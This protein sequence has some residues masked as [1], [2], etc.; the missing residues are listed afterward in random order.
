MPPGPVRLTRR[1]S[2][3]ARR[4]RRA[5]SSASRPI[6]G[7]GGAGRAPPRGPA[8]PR[9]G[10]A[11]GAPRDPPEGGPAVADAADAAGGP[12]IGDTRLSTHYRHP[13]GRHPGQI[14][15]SLV[16]PT[17]WGRRWGVRL[18]PEGGRG[19]RVGSTS[20]GEERSAAMHPTELQDLAHARQEALLEEAERR[21]ARRR[22]PPTL[23]HSIERSGTARRTAGR[24]PPLD[25]PAGLPGGPGPPA[26][27]EPG[28]GEAEGPSGAGWAPAAAGVAPGDCSGRSGAGRRDPRSK[29]KCSRA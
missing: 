17:E 28:S 24:L 27:K 3:R 18:M 20:T 14:C 12:G 22:A 9:R 21:R 7:P 6:S 1:A 26:Q 4:S 29:S 5:R 23:T 19:S 8:E 2:G 15:L 25:A 11:A 13:E 10:G 16:P